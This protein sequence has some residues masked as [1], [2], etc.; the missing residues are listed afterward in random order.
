MFASARINLTLW[1]VAILMLIS[2]FFSLAFYQASTIEVSRIL[3]RIEMDEQRQELGLMQ[4]RNRPFDFPSIEELETIKARIRFNLLILNGL[5]LLSGGGASYV[6][7]GKTLKPI[8]R[9]VEQQ[10][11][12]ISDASHELRTPIAT[13]RA[14]MEGQLLEQKITDK[15]ARRLITSNLEEV[16][17]LQS[18]SNDLLTLMKLHGASGRAKRETIA[19]DAVLKQS[20]EKLHI[21]AQNKSITIKSTIKPAMVRGNARQLQQVFMSLIEN[22]V[23]YSDA[24]T[25]ISVT[26]KKNAHAKYEISIEDQGVGIAAKDLP[27]IFGRFYRS[28]ESRSDDGFGL[29]LSIAKGIVDGHDGSI[30]VTSTLGKGSTFL[31][32][33]PLAKQ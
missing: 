20:I 14:E 3:T 6:L 28:Q 31:V 1:Y 27:H 12:F 17:A 10:Q 21:L 2:F 26:G 5:I 19:I 29:G 24:Q 15:Q 22:A 4:H 18:L 32:R 16:S 13:L 7:A 33:L 9:M 8:Q 23:K 25:T 11:Q 30:T